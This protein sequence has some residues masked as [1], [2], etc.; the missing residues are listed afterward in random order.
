MWSMHDKW[1]TCS[2]LLVLTKQTSRPSST[3]PRFKWVNLRSLITHQMPASQVA[4]LQFCN[5]PHDLSQLSLSQCSVVQTYR[6]HPPTFYQVWTAKVVPFNDWSMWLVDFVNDNKII[7][8][9]KLKI[10]T[11]TNPLVRPLQVSRWVHDFLTSQNLPIQNL[12]KVGR[13]LNDNGNLP[14]ITNMTLLLS[15]ILNTPFTP[16]W[17]NKGNVTA[18]AVFK[19]KWM[20]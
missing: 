3:N 2:L 20:V 11:L 19:L 4:C 7:G 15:S 1:Q 8:C 9:W 16:L 13:D 14:P 10:S 18:H 17:C 12:L 5:K 6:L